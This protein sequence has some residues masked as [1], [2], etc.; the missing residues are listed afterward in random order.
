MATDPPCKSI[1]VPGT[2]SEQHSQ[3][4]YLD[5]RSAMA[6]ATTVAAAT[7][8][9]M[10][11]GRKLERVRSIA[12]VVAELLPKDTLAE[13]PIL[14]PC[15]PYPPAGY[16]SCARPSSQPV[17]SQSGWVQRGRHADSNGGKSAERHGR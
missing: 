2:A 10:T 8:V 11:P 17:G 4:E 5:K 3:H 6:D 15:C 16:R 7:N 9:I 14:L 1:I 12:A 13:V